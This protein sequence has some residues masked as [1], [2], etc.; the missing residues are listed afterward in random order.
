MPNQLDLFVETSLSDQMCNE[1]NEHSF[2]TISFEKLPPSPRMLPR[3]LKS[4]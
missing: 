2:P 4:A 1:I 3:T